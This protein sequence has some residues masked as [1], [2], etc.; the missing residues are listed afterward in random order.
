MGTKVVARM[1]IYCVQPF[2]RAGP[3]KLAR[4]ELRQFRD[5]ARARR[6]GEAA[7]RRLGGALVY[8]VAGDPDYDN[9]D[10]PRFMARIGEVPDVR[11]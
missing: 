3:T 7:A 6:A 5:E 2:W 11:F 9:W 1:T 10:A 4:G 8:S